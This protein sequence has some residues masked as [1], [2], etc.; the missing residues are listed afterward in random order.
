MT[1]PVVNPT[2]AKRI[3]T[4]NTVRT[5]V[6]LI[7]SIGFT[8]AV[9]KLTGGFGNP[10]AVA[11]VAGV[12]TVLTYIQNYLESKGISPVLFGFILKGVETGIQDWSG[13]TP[14]K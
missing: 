4:Y 13:A 14:N 12:H 7:V 3:A 8:A 5:I 11:I 10:A 9:S 1:V 6:R 2:A